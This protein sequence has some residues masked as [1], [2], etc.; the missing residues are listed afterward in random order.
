MS[1]YNELVTKLREIFQIDRPELDFGIYRILNARA[2]EINR[3]LEERLPEKVKQ[4]LSAGSAAQHAQ[5]AQEVKDKE[6]QYLADGVDP[7]TV[8]KVL[9]LRQKLA[10]YTTGANEHENAVFSH[11]LA[12]FSR[13]FDNGDFIS[14][15]RYKG[16]TYAIPYA[17]EEVMLHWANKDQYYTKSGENFANYSFKLEDGRT[18]HFRLVA[19]DTAKDNRK[20]N[21]KE[22]RFAL[23]ERK[24]VT[25]IDEQGEEFEEELLPVEEV[26]GPAAAASTKPAAKELIIRF[27]Y[28]ATPKGTKQDVLAAQAVE[29]V[30]ADAAVKARWLGLGQRAPTEKNPQRTL[31]EKHLS[32]YTT[33]N[34]ADYFIHKDLGGFLR[35]ELDFYIK[36]EV[37]HLDDVQNAGAFANIEKSLRVIQCFRSIALELISFLAQLED[38]QKKLWLKKKFVVS[39]HYCVTL[40]RVPEDLYSEIAANEK[41]WAQWHDLGMRDSSTKGTL[42]DL[43][44]APHL[45]VDTAL[46]DAVFRADLLKAIP[47]LDASI[48]GL[49]IH[50]DNF[51]ALNLLGERY[52]EKVKCVYIDPPYNTASNSIPYKNTFKHSAWATM[53]D[54]RVGKLKRLIPEDGAIFVSIDKHERQNLEHVLSLNFGEDNHV[55]ELIWAMN[56]NNSQA[57]NYSTNHEYVLVYAKNRQVAEQDKSMFREPKP[58]FA[59][60]MELVARLNPHYPP[61]AEIEA[62]LR[63]LYR[64]HQIEFRQEVEAQGLE[65]DDEKGNDPWKGLFNYNGAEYRDAN[66]RL[67][68]EAEAAE[69]KA[70]IWIW[71]EGDLSM[72][73]SKQSPTV[74]DINHPNYRWYR[75]TH[76]ITGAPAP[77]PKSGWKVAYDH[78]PEN[79][80]KR[81]FTVLDADGRI[82]WGTDESKVPR[83]K[84]MLHEVETNVG[85]SV[86]S[87]Y[88]DGE[89]QTHDLF[90]RSGVFLAPKHAS[91]VSRFILH[92]TRSDSTVLDC[93]GGSGSTAHAVFTANRLDG[94]KRRY[95][96]VE[97]GDYFN[98]IIKPRMQKV[99]YSAEW[100]LGKPTA[101]EAGVSHAFK[102]LKIEGYEDTLNNLQLRRPSGTSDMFNDIPKEAQ[103]DYLLRYMLDV[104]SRSSLLSVDDFKKPFDYLLNVAVDSAGAF[105]PRRIDLVETFN[106][107]IGLRVKHIDAQPERGFVTVT[108]TLP[109]GESCLVLWRDCE[110][111]DYEG[112]TKLCDKLA[113][114]PADNEYDVVYL[115][116]DHNIPTVL[117]Q[118][119]EE[120][121]ATRV[122][123]LRQIEPEFLDRMFS[124][125]DV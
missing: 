21:D 18:V 15:R 1:K 63:K 28:K 96:T 88:S 47:D 74:N 19:A 40:D 67:V 3:Y 56:T 105:E 122:L 106:Y 102:V 8:P 36:N 61:V 95:I 84:R 7:A 123:K 115:N 41:Q 22:R 87:D 59:E 120:G 9:E 71:Q 86:F 32:D 53:M 104:E 114:N 45:M 39:S 34:T 35:R 12:F 31:L 65:W 55:E 29:A 49:L 98:T 81:S 116:G 54:N 69:R 100:R 97:Q 70:K 107:L 6:A 2:G 111:L 113:I 119:A 43:K 89:K 121:G 83:I 118:T 94:G 90:N 48:D 77:H 112:I 101:P 76:P 66:G 80:G 124:T 64:D 25:R 108:G 23:V 52:R 91:F 27:E 78:D 26:N 46:F 57:P 92:S 51:Q 24:T 72:P 103:D 79:P 73:A 4:A 68:P 42:N 37:M 10:Q 93:F 50:S 13:Y 58:G 109:S 33:K 16:D 17:G 44:S 5:V 14:Q 62:E 82:A 20:D 125:E 38:F 110:K 99:A 11:L 117:T 30:L 60:V 85:K 75:P